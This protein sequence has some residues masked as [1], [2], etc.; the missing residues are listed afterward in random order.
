MIELNKN[1]IT[2]MTF[3]LYVVGNAEMVVRARRRD[4]HDAR[5]RNPCDDTCLA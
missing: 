4:E 5:K 3:L 1:P 2:M